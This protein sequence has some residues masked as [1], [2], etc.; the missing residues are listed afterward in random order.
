MEPAA[1]IVLA[2]SPKRI[3]PRCYALPSR[4]LRLVATRTQQG[5]MDEL[6]NLRYQAKMYLSQAGQSL[7]RHFCLG[8]ILVV[9]AMAV[10]YHSSRT[11]IRFSRTSDKRQSRSRQPPQYEVFKPKRFDSQPQASGDRYGLTSKLMPVLQ[12]NYH[13]R[14]F[15]AYTLDRSTIES[16]R[17]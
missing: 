17:P 10:Y 12:F 13:W 4:L 8:P 7:T 1:L 5:V 16:C 9:P 6:L 2:L 14:L 3:L 11:V 15:S